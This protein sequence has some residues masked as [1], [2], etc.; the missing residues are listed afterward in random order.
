MNGR[1]AVE[2]IVAAVVLEAGLFSVPVPTP[3]VVSA[4]FSSVVIMAVVTT[5][6]TPLGL[7]LLLKPKSE[8]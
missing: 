5:F 6:L 3:P 1:G 7:Q 8:E 4:V 2:L